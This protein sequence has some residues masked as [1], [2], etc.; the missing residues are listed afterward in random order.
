M[1][2][3]IQ[4]AVSNDWQSIRSH[5]EAAGLPVEDLD[6]SS[7]NRFFIARSTER[8]FLGAVG[9]EQF[10]SDGLL[11]SLVVADHAR[12]LGLGRELVA[13][14]EQY[15][16]G[17]GITALWLLTIDA[18][19]FFRCLGFRSTHRDAVPDAVRATREFSELCPA[20]AFL[21]RKILPSKSGR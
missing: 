9:M 4:Q 16:V 12:G 21:M 17:A 1:A 18:D 20:S 7:M 8:R 13:R 10:G 19:N 5:L 3:E 11:R 2:T 14:L 6:A 15:A